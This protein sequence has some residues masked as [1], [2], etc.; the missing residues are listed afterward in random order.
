MNR[1]AGGGWRLAVLGALLCSSAP[2]RGETPRFALIASNGPPEQRINLVFFAEGFTAAQE[3]AFQAQADSVAAS[4]FAIAPFREY[5]RFFNLHTVFVP[6][7]QAGSDH[8]SQ[9]YYRNT[10]FNS[11]YDTFGIPELLTIPPNEFDPNSDNGV[12]RVEALLREG[13]TGY[14]VPIL[15][16]NDLAYGGAGGPVLTVSHTPAA[17]EILAHEL[18]HTLAGLGDEY[19]TP[20]PGYPESEEP[21]TTRTSQRNQVRW[22][23]WIEESVPVPTPA[24]AA[25]AMKVG[26]FEGAHYQAKG[27]YR[28]KLDCR[29][30]NLGAP[31]CEVCRETL[32]TALYRHV[33]VVQSW[34]PESEKLTLGVDK[35]VLLELDLAWAP[36]T[37]HRVE[38]WMNGALLA[39]ETNRSLALHADRLVPGTHTLTARVAATCPWVRNDPLGAMRDAREWVVHAEASP[40]A[41]SLASDPNRGTAAFRLTVEG[42]ASET[43]ILESRVGDGGWRAVLTNHLAGSTQDL[44]ISN[45]P[46]EATR[47]FRTRKP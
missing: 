32:V 3:G 14:A 42:G 33:P 24:T 21:N 34:A 19:E 4:L 31:F 22:K 40:F 47:W 25:Y 43:F 44:T 8:P 16:V 39:G 37:Q 6:S 13:I 1:R 10:Y 18:G 45:N 46:A 26:L 9:S 12:G 5:Q 17:G 11:S 41:L 27:W 35:G 2:G 7:E 30:R 15:L 28:P 23:A 29:M 38:W 20:Y 36:D